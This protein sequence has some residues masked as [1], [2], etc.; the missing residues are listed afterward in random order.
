VCRVHLWG[1][2]GA[3]P[4]ST[5]KLGIFY[6]GGFQSEL[7]VNA[8]GYATAEKYELYEKMIRSGLKQKGVE[9]KFDLLEFQV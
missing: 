8:T 9:D 3:P 1:I 5:T 6:R 2:R 7:V 4:P